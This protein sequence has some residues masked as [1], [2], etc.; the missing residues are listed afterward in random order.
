MQIV[1]DGGDSPDDRVS[2][3]GEKELYCRVLVEG[4]LSRIDQLVDVTPERWNPVWIVPIKPE[5]KLDELPLIALRL[6]GI[7]ANGC[8]RADQIRSI[9]R[10]T[11]WNASS[12]ESSCDSVCV[13][14]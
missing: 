9:S 14:M 8:R 6:Y 11:F 5:W 1:M 13:A 7:D 10:P 3:P 12:T 2:P 4:V